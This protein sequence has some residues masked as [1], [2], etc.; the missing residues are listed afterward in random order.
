M[1]QI[2]RIR[3]LL[4]IHFVLAS[5]II[6]AQMTTRWKV[7]VSDLEGSTLENAL[8]GGF[9][10]PQFSAIFLDGDT[11][12]DLF[13]FDRS[14]WKILT[15]VADPGFSS[16]YRYA[17]EYEMSFPELQE[18][19]LLRDFNGDSI[20]DIFSYS[21]TGVPGIDVYQGMR[22]QDQIT[23]V[24]KV[25]NNPVGVIGYPTASGAVT[26]VYVAATDIPAL[27]DIDSDGDLDIL[28]F[29]SDG[30]KLYYYRNMDIERG[31]PAGSF[32][33]VL[34][35][36]C[37][38]KMVESFNTNEVILSMD[39]LN[40]PGVLQNA[41]LHSGSTVTTFDSDQDGDMDLL[42]GDLTYET[43]LFLENGG[44]AETSWII[45]Q[46]S[47]FPS[48]ET[49]IAIP[50]FPAAY[51]L[52]INHDGLPDLVVTPNE[53]D[54]KEN[55]DQVWYY[56]AQGQGTF[57]RKTRAF[58]N[59]EMLDFGTEA[60][61]CFLDFNGD[62]LTDILVGS[63][64]HRNYDATHPSQLF[65][66]Q[67]IGTAAIPEYQLVDEDWLALS[68]MMMED[69]DALFPTMVDIDGDADQDMV[70][71]NKFGKLIYIEN[72]GIEN[73]PFEMGAL[74]YP[75]F[76][77]DVGFSSAPAF[78]DIDGDG[79]MDMLIGEE[80]GTINYFHN[81][82]SINAP[83]FEPD[84]QS[85]ENEEEFGGIDARQNNAVFGMSA[86]QVFHSQDK[87][88]LL[89]GTNFGNMLL[90]DITNV[91]PDDVLLALDDHPVAQLRDGARSKPALSDIDHDGYLDLV[92]G[93][94]RGGI[95]LYHSPFRTSQ[96][97]P[98]REIDDPSLV[99]MYPNP[100][101]KVIFIRS[102][103]LSIKNIRLVNASG[104]QVYQWSGIA[105]DLE[106]NISDYTPGLY[107]ATIIT[108]RGL[109]VKPWLKM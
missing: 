103:D 53:K 76:D 94:G 48:V 10:S 55:V 106:I 107:Y 6:N 45:S 23:F 7:P 50:Y 78:A 47:N 62:G 56:S 67:N 29:Q 24:K 22:D 46:T 31:L 19:A 75:W 35:D 109:V 69:L 61:P 40:C 59:E 25:F 90:Y 11:L 71:G 87:T 12:Q 28:T 73:G 4:C 82:G 36:K 85:A 3:S 38:G 9:N 2:P 96:M 97:V 13:V 101:S 34:E 91:Q 104:Q 1:K 77:I 66:F 20:M 33:F 43:M 81:L 27:D 51:F 108:D 37:W 80:R 57:E 58:I 39:S 17:P 41:R 74:E 93:T 16:G 52:D 105:S 84:P 86:P 54:S 60:N 30:T 65:L 15:Y 5:L 92:I 21:T 26:N 83:F 95:N 44:S 14:G 18:W 63:R 64:F 88:L 79:V 100:A 72:A 32:D 8:S 68:T 98:V 70:I 89:V 102:S 49:P 99:N 42:L